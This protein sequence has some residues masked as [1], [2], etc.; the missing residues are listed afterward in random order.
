MVLQPLQE[1]II[2]TKPR[3]VCYL[4]LRLSG[5]AKFRGRVQLRLPASSPAKQA[6]RCSPGSPYCRRRQ[7]QQRQR[8]NGRPALIRSDNAAPDRFIL[9]GN[10]KLMCQQFRQTGGYYF[11]VRWLRH[12]G[13]ARR[14]PGRRWFY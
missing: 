3:V 10:D 4:R 14:E 13:A 9:S 2:V 1:I 6:G 12:A 5:S 8:F 11:P 7:A